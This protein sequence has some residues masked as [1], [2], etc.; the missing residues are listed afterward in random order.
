[1]SSCIN[2]SYLLLQYHDAAIPVISIYLKYIPVV[3]FGLSCVYNQL[4]P[5][6][7]DHAIAQLLE[8]VSD[9]I[10]VYYYYQEGTKAAAN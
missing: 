3:S 4:C 6:A 8:L 7:F 2:D 9:F 10:F 5:F 1:M